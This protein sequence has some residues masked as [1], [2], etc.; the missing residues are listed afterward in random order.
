MDVLRDGSVVATDIPVGTR[1]FVWLDP[2][3]VDLAHESYCYSV[4]VRYRSSGNTSQH[5][6]PRCYWLADYSRVEKRT[7][8][9]ITAS[10]G[11]LTSHERGLY[12]RDWGT[13]LSPV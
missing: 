2:S 11:I 7:G 3:S 6:K 5:A 12:F 1:S 13:E 4:R 10:G 8:E 9:T